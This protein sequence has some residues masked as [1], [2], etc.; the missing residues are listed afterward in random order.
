LIDLGALDGK[1]AK[2]KLTILT[3]KFTEFS[4]MI[5]QV[6]YYHQ[7]FDS[8]WTS[9]KQ[10]LVDIKGLLTAFIKLKKKK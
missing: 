10:G 9:M 6:N 3:N 8:S 7:A 4:N 5:V 2:K 1:C